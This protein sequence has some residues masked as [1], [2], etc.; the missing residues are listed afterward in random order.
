MARTTAWLERNEPTA[1]LIAL[2]A[3][4]YLIPSVQA[5]LPID[6]PDIW[7]R[8]RMGEW[9]VENYRVPFADYFSATDLGETL[10][11][12]QLVVRVGSVSRAS[13]I[14]SVRLGVLRGC[15]GA[16]HRVCRPPV[17]PAIRII[18]AN[19]GGGTRHGVR[20][21]E[22]GDVAATMAFHDWFLRR[23]TADYYTG[24]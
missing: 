1:R 21:D 24:A 8:F 13:K 9:I 18:A 20:S 14:R 17:D 15:L 2:I 6:D 5:M 10:D 4:L 23:R 12:V 19:G 16:R 7:W 3:L 22:T 11:R